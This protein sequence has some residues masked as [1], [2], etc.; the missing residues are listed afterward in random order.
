MYDIQSLTQRDT[1]K[2]VEQLTQKKHR[3]ELGFLKSLIKDIVANEA[4]EVIGGRIWQLDPENE[5]YVLKYQFGEVKRIPNGYSMPIDDQPV[6]NDLVTHRT[7][8]NSETDEL[9]I[10][11]GINVYSITGVG[12]IEKLPNGKYYK[13]V[14]GFNAPQILQSFFE[15]LNIISSV[16]T[17]SL[18]NLSNKEQHKKITQDIYRASE[19]QRKLLPEHS[20]EFHDYEIFGLCIPDSAVGGD[21]FDY[22]RNTAE[23][24]ES[25][26]IIISDAVSKG[27][28]AAIQALFVSGAIR[29]A[30][31]FAPKIS[32]LFS[33]LNTLICDTF[34]F[35]DFVTLFFCE[36]TESSKGL[37]LYANAGHISPIQYSRESD[38][39]QHLPPTGGLLGIIRDQKFKV[40]NASMQPGDILIL[41]TDGITETQNKNGEFFGEEPIFDI[42]RKNKKRPPK[43]IAALIIEAVE[44]FSIESTYTDDKTIVVIKKKK[45]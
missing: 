26:G 31:T 39:F 14:L 28:P 9:L 15:T 30:M 34:P 43:E 16:A 35:D 2:L 44:K 4:F 24:E 17:I 13:Y 12:D 41:F 37:V 19:I 7:R 40:E 23:E 18:R 33:R 6:L 5:A 27:L 1:Y 11:K 29:M 38:S 32:H 8:L 25:V 36:L 45:R 21:Y 42:V 10:N 20:L 22:I 3:T